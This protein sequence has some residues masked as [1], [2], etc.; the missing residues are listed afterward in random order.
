[1]SATVPTVVDQTPLSRSYGYVN[2]LNQIA[3]IL[4]IIIALYATV[5]LLILLISLP[6]ALL[7]DMMSLAELPEPST[8]RGFVADTFGLGLS[9]TG[10]AIVMLP[11]LLLALL[12]DAVVMPVRSR[13]WLS[14]SVVLSIP[15]VTFLAG[16]IGAMADGAGLGYAAWRGLA[17]IAGLYLPAAGDNMSTVEILVGATALALFLSSVSILL[18]VIICLVGVATGRHALSARR[19]ALPLRVLPRAALETLRAVSSRAGLKLVALLAAASLTGAVIFQANRIFG[20]PIE[21]GIRWMAPIVGPLGELMSNLIGSIYLVGPFLIT[22]LAGF[23]ISSRI[24]GGRLSRKALLAV[25]AMHLVVLAIF[26]LRGSEAG[27]LFMPYIFFAPLVAIVPIIR[28]VAGELRYLIRISW[29]KAYAG[30]VALD[31]ERILFL[32]PF[33]FDAVVLRRRFRLIDWL[34]PLRGFSS[35]LEEVTAE[36]AFRVAPLV[37]L[38]D[39]RETRPELGAI[40]AYASDDDW[41]PYIAG[42]ISGSTRILFIIGLSRYTGW[43]TDRILEADAI[44]KTVFVLPPDRTAAVAYLRENARVTAALDLDEERIAWIA[45]NRVKAMFVSRG[46][47]V[48]VVG[49][50]DDEI[51]YKLAVDFA[52]ERVGLPQA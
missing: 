47:T 2:R 38:A 25:A 26:T 34:L 17:L 49:R 20:P 28:H 22:S 10:R 48:I 40:R 44:A 9:L 5:S 13:V 14:V 43:E 50:G 21:A 39:P 29:L 31:S 36:S 12:R 30:V 6:G 24:S 15:A 42:Q 45:A 35:R 52:M 46:R 32:R 16:M 19:S 1:M 8:G 37:A 18:C 11:I 27:W 7:W 41:Q 33:V 51:D 3:D 23:W 4:P